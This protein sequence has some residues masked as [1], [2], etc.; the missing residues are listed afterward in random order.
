MGA[1]KGRP[2]ASLNA[3]DVFKLLDPSEREELAGRLDLESL[4]DFALPITVGELISHVLTLRLPFVQMMSDISALLGQ[5]DASVR[6]N[7]RF[8][9][10]PESGQSLAIDFGPQVRHAVAT[11][12][13]QEGLQDHG[14]QITTRLRDLDRDVMLLC[15]RARPVPVERY[16]SAGAHLRSI[17]SQLPQGHPERR[18]IEFITDAVFSRQTIEYHPL[19]W[20]ALDAVYSGISR[21]RSLID[22]VSGTL[23][24]NETLAANLSNTV[25][26]LSGH[27]QQKRQSPVSRE[28]PHPRR[29]T[30]EGEVELISRRIVALEEAI[31]AAADYLE[32][33]GEIYDFLSLEIW[34]QRWRV[35]ELWILARVVAVLQGLGGVLSETDRIVDGCWTLKFTTDHEPALSLH[36]D[37]Q[38]LDIYYQYYQSSENGGDMPDIAVKLRGRG[39][40]AVFDPKHGKSYSRKDLNRVCLRYAQA[41]APSLSCVVNYFETRAS[42]ELK[43]PARSIV[44]YGMR[45]KA[46]ITLDR[47]AEETV[48][49]VLST[50]AR[51]GLYLSSGKT[52]VVLFDG[53]SST[54]AVRATLVNKLFE[55]LDEKSEPMRVDSTV[56]VFGD[57]ILRKGTLTELRNGTILQD[58]PP[59]GTNL[60]EAVRVAVAQLASQRLP[61]QLWIVSDGD[62]GDGFDLERSLAASDV[63]IT[64]LEHTGGRA[65]TKLAQLSRKIGARFL[66]F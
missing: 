60:L 17:G 50:W 4:D 6:G 3:E 49:A 52:I 40:V 14:L 35:Y 42:E 22:R 31:L 66:C 37:D 30:N 59:S 54:Q 57:R 53:S 61:R 21:L 36:L 20:K 24:A 11:A 43:S 10:L 2:S 26:H 41:F 47:F 65:D 19:D 12:L 18:R 29:C 13:N 27:L 25:S 5:L 16:T 34:R 56:L 51:Q 33:I 64:I 1:A 46:E 38:H 23:A 39:F 45:P 63:Q 62:S 58:L 55:F 48:Q 9:V 44:I 15:N 8:I 28:Y 32:S 7:I